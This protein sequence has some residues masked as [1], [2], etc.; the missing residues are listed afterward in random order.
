MAMAAERLR[1]SHIGELLTSPA[2]GRAAKDG[3]GNAR[4]PAPSVSAAPFG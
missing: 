4:S 3:Y 2:K 1:L